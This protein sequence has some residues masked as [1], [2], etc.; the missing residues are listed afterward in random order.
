MKN[1]ISRF[2]NIGA[3]VSAGLLLSASGCKKSSSSNP[4]I[5]FQGPRNAGFESNTYWTLETGYSGLFSYK[6]GTGFLP[7]E[8]VSYGSFTNYFPNGAASTNYAVVNIYQD[9]VDF[10][11]S[12]TMTFDYIF[13]YAPYWSPMPATA[14]VTVQFLFTANGTTTLWQQTINAATTPIQVKNASVTIPSLPTAGRF[15]IQLTAQNGN[16]T[17]YPTGNFSIDNI[18][19]N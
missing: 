8:G 11:H 12:S 6:T 4:S 16:S 18:R 7:S 14:S 13:T 1:I 2:L 17:F 5:P 9:N 19:V 3:I 10:S 15:L